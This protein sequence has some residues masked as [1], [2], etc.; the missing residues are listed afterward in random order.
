MLMTCHYPD[1]GCFSDWLK[2]ISSFAARPIENTSQIWGVTSHEYG[3]SA[4]IAGLGHHFGGK[5]VGRGVAW[6]ALSKSVGSF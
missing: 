5:T 3:I 4:L 6:R 1:L 2:K